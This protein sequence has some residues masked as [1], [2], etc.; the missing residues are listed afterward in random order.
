MKRAQAGC[1][2]DQADGLVDFVEALA[3]DGSAEQE[4]VAEI[5]ARRVELECAIAPI[6]ILPLA[7]ELRRI[8][9]V[10]PDAGEHARE[11]LH[12]LLRVAAM[13]PQRVQLHQFARVVLVD[14]SDGVLIVVQ[15]LQHGGMLER[16]E[17]QVLEMAERMR[18]DRPLLVV[19]DQPAQ[20]GLVLMDAEVIEPEPDHLFLELR[21]R[22]DRPQQLA[23]GSPGRR[24]CCPHHSMPFWPAPCR[25]HP[26]W[27]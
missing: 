25:A 22:I 10:D 5:V 21:R 18:P 19:A 16:G 4:L 23:R 24:A 26:A 14:V 9:C 3:L 15:I 8:A 27:R 12:V 17:H 20:I 13:H 11:L 6:Q 1:A 2:H 7:L